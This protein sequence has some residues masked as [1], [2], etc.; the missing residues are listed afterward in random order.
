[1]IPEVELL[2]S[3]GV[4]YATREEQ[5]ITQKNEEA[6]PKQKWLSILDVSRSESKV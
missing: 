4:W 1:M 5:E 6:G 2:R 3:L